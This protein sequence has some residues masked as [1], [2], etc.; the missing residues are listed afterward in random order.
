M[1]NALATSNTK[2]ARWCGSAVAADSRTAGPNPST[3]SA[4]DRSASSVTLIGPAV[5]LSAATAEPH[6][7]AGFVFD[8][9]SAFTTFY[10]ECPVLKAPA[11]QVRESRLALCALTLRVLLKGLDLLGI[12]VP[13]RM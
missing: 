11:E 2:P 9:A 12:P 5:R 8:V 1:V 10:E 3:V 13:D 6:H 4:K 7:L